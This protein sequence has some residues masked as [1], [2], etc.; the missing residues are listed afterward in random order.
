M[1]IK[2]SIVVPVYNVEKY[3][4]KCIL[5]LVN[6]TYH[7]IEI[8]L[9]DDGSTDNSGSICDKYAR[10]Y[11]NVFVLHK[12][13]GG[14]SSARNFALQHL[15]G[16]YV[17]FVDSD[18]YVEYF[19]LEYMM[20]PIRRCELDNV[21]MVI[22]PIAETTTDGIVLRAKNLKNTDRRLIYSESMSNQEALEA[23]CYGYKFGTSAC[24]KL[25]SVKIAR[26]FPFPI[27]KI[28][29]D[30]ATIYKMIGC[31]EKI[32]VL[33]YPMYYYVMRNGSITHCKWSPAV[34]DLVYASNNLLKYIDS[35]FPDIHLAGVYC[36]FAS[37][38]GFYMRAFKESG[39]LDIIAP[40]RSKLLNLLPD[41]M[42]NNKLTIIRKSQCFMLVYTPR[43]YRCLRQIYQ[44]IIFNRVTKIIKGK[45]L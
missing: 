33:D 36:F 11:N 28:Y 1:S 31:S 24:G 34:K 5:S 20:A 38:N 6:Q 44:Y 39:Y 13:N 27:G 32:I 4:E 35:Y 18:D 40:V 22:C 15:T 8:L 9:V 26:Q 16:E 7:N 21:D 29:E 3:L 12:E 14:L 45:I 19:Y 37:M 10:L 30:L 23:M 17:T 42:N 2:I 41:I 43:L 25:I